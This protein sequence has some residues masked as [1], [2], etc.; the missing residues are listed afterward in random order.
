MEDSNPT[1]P[2]SVK[3]QVQEVV[4]GYQA[5]VIF[6]YVGN[7]FIEWSA[8]INDV[9]DRAL[10]FSVMFNERHQA[11]MLDTVLFPFTAFN[12]SEG[13]SSEEIIASARKLITGD[14]RVERALFIAYPI[15]EINTPSG[16][17]S[18]KVAHII[19]WLR[20]G[21]KIETEKY[22]PIIS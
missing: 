12:I 6:Q 5:N 15:L 20:S 10:S 14:Y 3:K 22:V 17:I 4:Y 8:D 7:Q 2:L 19:S 13:Y 16:K 9:H 11:S 1:V 21:K 18:A